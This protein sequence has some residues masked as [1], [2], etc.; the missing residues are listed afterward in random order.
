MKKIVLM[1]AVMLSLLV[2]CKKDKEGATP[3]EEPINQVE[4]KTQLKKECYEGIL[5]K[6]TITLQLN[7]R[8]NEVKPGKLRY[9]FFEKDKN[10]GIIYG[11]LSGD[12]VFATYAFKSE[13]RMSKREVVFLKKGNIIIEGYGDVAT[14]SIGDVYFKDKKKLY[15]DSKVILTKQDCHK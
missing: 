7:T 4:D 1:G 13:G 15:F 10:E 2:S 14:D 5:Q 11:T 12:T 9:N 3:G 6:D 8:G